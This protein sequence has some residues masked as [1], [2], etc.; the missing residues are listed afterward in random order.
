MSE[1]DWK[2]QTGYTGPGTAVYP[3]GPGR[4]RAHDPLRVRRRQRIPGRPLQ[5]TRASS[6]GCGPKG[7]PDPG[8]DTSSPGGTAPGGFAWITG[9][10]GDCQTVTTDGSWVPSDTGADGCPGVIPRSLHREG[11]LRPRLRLPSQRSRRPALRRGR[12]STARTAAAT[13]SSTTSPGSRPSTSRATSSTGRTS[14][15]SIA[16]GRNVCGGAG[17]EGG[18][19]CLFGWFLQDLLPAG[20]IV[21]PSTTNPNYGPDHRQARWL[22]DTPH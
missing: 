9:P 7:N 8:C 2:S 3:P 17:G 6:V 15:P 12:R 19:Q 20:D 11:R 18:Q 10:D 5:P 21:P 4:S 14:A 1:C 13:T 16:T 22:I